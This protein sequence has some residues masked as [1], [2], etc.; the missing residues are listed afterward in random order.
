MA[1]GLTRLRPDWS[2]EESF[3]SPLFLRLVCLVWLSRPGDDGHS[4]YPLIRSE[5]LIDL[6]LLH[7][8]HPLA[9][10]TAINTRLWH[11]YKIGP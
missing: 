9:A 7:P 2:V 5:A 11:M 10:S 8:K 3:C 4:V 1:T 6:L